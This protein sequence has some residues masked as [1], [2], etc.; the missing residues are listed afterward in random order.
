M[1]QRC[2]SG[3][4]P[5][6]CNI[7]RWAWM[8]RRRVQHMNEIPG[9]N[10]L[11]TRLFPPLNTLYTPEMGRPRLCENRRQ[12][13]FSLSEAD[14]KWVELQAHGNVSK[15]CRERILSDRNPDHREAD[16]PRARAVSAGAGSAGTS[17]R[18][19]ASG[20]TCEHGTKKGYRCYNCG[21]LAK[22]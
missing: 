16:V 10:T 17:E 5:D 13:T 22:C 1:L 14:Y 11:G 8:V 7:K 4:S 2:A 15:W 19:S 12:V 20:K 9:V 21:G 3:R 18:H 6:N